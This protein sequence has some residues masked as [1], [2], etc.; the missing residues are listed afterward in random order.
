MTAVISAI[1]SSADSQ[2]ILAATEV[3]YSFYA[4][5][6]GRH[7]TEAHLVKGTR[8]S[9]LVIGG[10][11]LY[12]ALGADKLVFWLVLF[13]WAG[14]GSA[15]GPVILLSLFWR[16]VTKWGVLAGMIA[17]SATVFCWGLSPALK[18]MIYEG[19]PGFI[20][21]AS[22]CIVVSLLTKKGMQEDREFLL[23]L[24]DRSYFTDLGRSMRAPVHTATDAVSGR[25]G[26]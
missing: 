15:F 23:W 25:K 13:A 12:L 10:I 16:K 11:A 20:A 17:G 22:A 24:N 9:V 3:I 4:P 6:F 1:M 7:A 18:G 14:L 19:V 8:I 2:L 21:A 5:Y 26:G